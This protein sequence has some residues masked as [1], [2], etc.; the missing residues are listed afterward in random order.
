MKPPLAAKAGKAKM[1]A[2]EPREEA[3]TRRKQE[4]E[5]RAA[6]MRED[7]MRKEMAFQQKREQKRYQAEQDRLKGIP[8]QAVSKVAQPPNARKSVMS[9]TA[10]L[11]RPTPVSREQRRRDALFAEDGPSLLMIPVPSR[12]D[13]GPHTL[14]RGRLS[15][16]SSSDLQRERVSPM[17][18]KSG[19]HGRSAVSAHQAGAQRHERGKTALPDLELA[20]TSAKR[21]KRSIEEIED[22]LKLQRAGQYGSP[23][24][25]DARSATTSETSKFAQKTAKTSQRHTAQRAGRQKQDRKHPRKGEQASVGGSKSVVD[26][27]S[28]EEESV[29]SSEIDDEPSRRPGSYIWQLV[30]GDRRRPHYDSDASSSDMEADAEQVRREEARAARISRREDDELLAE[31]EARRAEKRRRLARQRAKQ[32]EPSNMNVRHTPSKGTCYR[33]CRRDCHAFERSLD[34]DLVSYD[35]L[36]LPPRV[37]IDQLVE[38]G[39]Y[40]GSDA[41]CI[42]QVTQEDIAGQETESEAQ[43]SSFEEP[44]RSNE[45]A[46]L[47]LIQRLVSL[48]IAS[49]RIMADIKPR[50]KSPRQTRSTRSSPVKHKDVSPPATPAKR[51]RVKKEEDEDEDVKQSPRPSPQLAKKLRQLETYNQTPYPDFARP[52]EADCHSVLEALCT[53]HRRPER[54]V[55]LKQARPDGPAG[56][57][58]VPDPLDA[59]I[60]TILSQNT[61]SANSTRAM[62]GLIERF[63]Y[64]DYAAIQAASVED[65]TESIATGGLANVKA[66]VIKKVLDQVQ[67]KRGKLD[68]TYL[69]DM[70]D[71]DVMRE[72]IS[73]DGVGFKTASCVL[74]FCLGRE[75]FAVDTHVFRLTKALNWVPAKADRET[76]FQH[77]DVK[78]PGPLKYPLHSLLIHHGRSCKNCSANGVLTEEPVVESCPLRPFLHGKRPKD[79]Q[80]DAPGEAGK[81]DKMRDEDRHPTVP[82]LL[83]TEGNIQAKIEPELKPK[84]TMH[85][86]HICKLRD[87]LSRYIAKSYDLQATHDPPLIDSDVA[88]FDST[89][90][91]VQQSHTDRCPSPNGVFERRHI[92][93]SVQTEKR[94]M[95]SNMLGLQEAQVQ[96]PQKRRRSLYI[97][98]G[99]LVFVLAILLTLPSHNDQSDIDSLHF[100]K[101]QHGSIW[102]WLSETAS[103]SAALLRSEIKPA[104]LLGGKAWHLDTSGRR[105]EQGRAQNVDL[106]SFLHSQVGQ[107]RKGRPIW[108]VIGGGFYLKNVVPQLVAFLET[109]KHADHVNTFKRTPGPKPD[110]QPDGI[111]R[112]LTAETTPKPSLL[113]ICLDQAC[114]STCAL[115]GLMCYIFD[116]LE[117]LPERYRALKA[118]NKIEYFSIGYQKAS[119]LAEIAGA[120]YSTVSSDLDIFFQGN[121]FEYLHDI[122]EGEYDIQM[123]DEGGDTLNIGFFAQRG[124]PAVAELWRQVAQDVAERNAWDQP[125]VN[126]YLQ[127]RPMRSHNQTV[128]PPSNNF[129]APTGLKVYVI[130]KARVWGRTMGWTPPASVVALHLTCTGPRELKVYDA[131]ECGF[132]HDVDHY[133]TDPPRI[134]TIGALAGDE[135][136]VAR[137]VKFVLALANATGRAFVP[138]SQVYVT[139]DFPG[140]S[141]IEFR[142]FVSKGQFPP[143]PEDRLRAANQTGLRLLDRPAIYHRRFA[144]AINVVKLMN[145]TS[146]KVLE[147]SYLR[148]AQRYALPTDEPLLAARPIDT[149][150][151][152]G[153]EQTLQLLQTEP[154]ASLHALTLMDHNDVARFTP[155]DDADQVTM[156]RTIETVQGCASICL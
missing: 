26:Q 86:L 15:Q 104:D 137:Q 55:K 116:K 92:A 37:D 147:P 60:R 45:L 39:Q 135:Q 67:E 140:I 17:P 107:P 61:S 8:A 103:N 90:T 114:M 20:R 75:S 113:V 51:R 43:L 98:T 74:L 58:S 130:D 154:Y 132:W 85:G 149:M 36:L 105:Y 38:D 83:K 138:P 65:V 96:P 151:L 52:S 152:A 95:W 64:G 78:I 128:W 131:K 13:V 18:T 72:L 56:C 12:I 79:Y 115:S 100:D 89:R 94:L 123:Q 59:L 35:A 10:H 2:A 70:E 80:D 150:L 62:K 40:D 11:A 33:R 102:R 97:L 5:E 4:G 3:E 28:E 57:G 153:Y 87:L 121:I 143:T 42:G 109:L 156:C 127:S 22:D 141:E 7:M 54:P 110:D 19:S 32:A 21:D 41:E 46:S 106:V 133:Y 31:E 99:S 34:S 148:Y 122:D 145:T 77:L 24:G 27:Q 6:R 73:F 44:E 29:D 117:D 101:A 69:H 139:S 48:Q 63:G 30:N 144:S 119:A 125:A 76:T 84:P 155:P 93:P 68:L 49:G 108:T 82:S 23:A 16:G 120:G 129:V 47:S 71:I 25:N 142:H 81:S 50:I 134:L 14:A 112:P 136:T 91:C 1:P 118:E 126:H 88:L 9:S 111:Y 53:V 124:T 66:K 146:V